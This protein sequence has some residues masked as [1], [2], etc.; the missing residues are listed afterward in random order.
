MYSGKLISS[1]N[2]DISNYFPH[3][4]PIESD[5]KITYEGIARLVMLDRYSQKDKHLTSLKTGDLVLTI[6]KRD[7]VFPTR[8]IG[9]VSSILSNGKYVITIEEEYVASIDPNM[10]ENEL[11]IDRVV[12]QKQEIEKPLEIFYEQIA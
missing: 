8:G 11:Q 6:I 12:V 9:Y 1:L 4:K 2:C 5:F 3:L 10:L 7:P